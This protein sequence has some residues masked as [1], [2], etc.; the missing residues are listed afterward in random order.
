MGAGVRFNKLVL[1]L[2]PGVQ[3]LTSLL[4]LHLR[5]LSETAFQ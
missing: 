4:D 2:L 1:V 5:A 3:A